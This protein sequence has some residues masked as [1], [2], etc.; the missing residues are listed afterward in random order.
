M[1]VSSENNV[2]QIQLCDFDVAFVF[3]DTPRQTESCS[4]VSAVISTLVHRE[5][6]EQEKERWGKPRLNLELQNGSQTT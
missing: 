4:S 5:K 6:R 2:L 1:I 3:A